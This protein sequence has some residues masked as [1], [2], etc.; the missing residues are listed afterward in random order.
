MRAF[1]KANF[2][3]FSPVCH[4][5]HKASTGGTQHLR[6]PRFWSKSLE[7]PQKCLLGAPK[8][9][10]KSLKAPQNCC[11]VAANLWIFVTRNTSAWVSVESPPLLTYKGLSI[12]TKIVNSI[13]GVLRGR[14][15]GERRRRLPES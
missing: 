15:R 12:R 13:R 14:A 10:L 9:T 7:L 5:P 6:P 2:Q 11:L 8:P 4:A 1:L 3:A